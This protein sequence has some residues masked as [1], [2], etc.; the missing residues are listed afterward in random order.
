M[1]TTTTAV[2]SQETTIYITSRPT[3]QAGVNANTLKYAALTPASSW[4]LQEAGKGRGSIINLS[5]S[6]E[7]GL[8]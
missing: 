5:C 7:S 8:P 6:G 2:D 4:Q 3:P 1:K